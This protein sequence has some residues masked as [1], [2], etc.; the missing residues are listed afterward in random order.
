MIHEQIV[1]R[2]RHLSIE[3]DFAR[4]IIRDL[5]HHM[6]LLPPNCPVRKLAQQNLDSANELRRD[7][8]ADI[9]KMADSEISFSI[10]FPSL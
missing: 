2:Y 1:T 8:Q 7:I 5:E 3:L 10:I 9:N 6:K 4:K